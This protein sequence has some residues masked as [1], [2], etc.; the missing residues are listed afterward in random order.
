M[1]DGDIRGWKTLCSDVNWIDYHGMWAKRAKDGS[2]YVLRWTNMIDAMGEHDCEADGVDT[3]ECEVK[4]VPLDELGEAELSKAL[5]CCGLRKD[6][7]GAIYSDG[8]DEVASA[9]NK[10]RAAFVAVEACIQYGLGEP[11]ETFTSSKRPL[12]LRAKARR[13]AEG[14]MRDA[15]ALTSALDRPVNALGSTAREYG[16]GDID[17]ALMRGTSATHKLMRKLHGIAES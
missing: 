14:Y 5:E 17:A 11:L 2:F 16:R 12:S 10:E 9:E 3:F 6:E 7:S 13:A 8:G 1:S 4:R 15:S